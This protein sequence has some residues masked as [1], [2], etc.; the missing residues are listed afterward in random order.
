MNVPARPLALACVLSLGCGGAPPPRPVTDPGWPAHPPT[1][2]VTCGPALPI[3]PHTASLRVRWPEGGHAPADARVT[4]DGEALDATEVE[5]G[6]CAAPGMHALVV[7]SPTDEPDGQAST[8]RTGSGPIEI[9]P[10]IETRVSLSRSAAPG[11]IDAQI[12]RAVTDIQATVASL[13]E[14]ELPAIA[15][16]AT[17]EERRV[18]APVLGAAFDA[19][20][21]RLARVS[22]LADE[23]G[24]AILRTASR[25]HET[26]SSAIAVTIAEERPSAD[27]L[28]AIQRAM[29]T[30]IDAAAAMIAVERAC[31]LY[32]D[33]EPRAPL[34]AVS[35]DARPYS[36]P[37]VSV[38]RLRVAIDDVEVL[39]SGSAEGEEL[40]EHT[41]ADGVVPPGEHVVR[42]E[43]TFSP[44]ADGTAG[45][46]RRLRVLGERRVSVPA[47][48]GRF[49]VRARDT[50]PPTAE[51]QQRLV[52]EIALP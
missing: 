31:P 15:Y 22:E 27:R 20:R 43:A 6:A 32:A 14:V 21:A 25:D 51:L 45:S 19:W 46:G 7:Q 39:D 17:P 38:A 41:L 44:R 37:S 9:L 49:V 33:Q 12:S 11:R 35:F 28:V 42:A 5:L 40:F 2:T 30:E 13:G 26:R 3:C 48:G 23:Q 47:S 34:A 16:D 18:F 24:D 52:V 8:V 36:T 1:Q 50:G 10:G 4:L 29:R